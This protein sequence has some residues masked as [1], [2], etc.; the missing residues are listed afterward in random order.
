VNTAVVVDERHHDG[1][2]FPEGPLVAV[3]GLGDERGQTGCGRAV[4]RLPQALPARSQP[5][6]EAD[7]H[8]ALVDHH[9]CSWPSRCLRA[10]VAEVPAGRWSGLAGRAVDPGDDG[11]SSE[12]RDVVLLGCPEE[13]ADAA[14][15]LLLALLWSYTRFALVSA[16]PEALEWAGS[17]VAVGGDMRRRSRAVLSLGTAVSPTSTAELDVEL[18]SDRGAGWARRSGVDDADESR[19]ADGEG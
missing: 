19:F 18:G 10:V 8:A 13:S 7:D 5:T 17:G 2:Q 4:V 11:S 1:S 15:A 12:R 14:A 6:L 9:G 3:G 16:P